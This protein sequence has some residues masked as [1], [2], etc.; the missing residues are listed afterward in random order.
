M[1]RLFLSNLSLRY[2]AQISCALFFSGEDPLL[3]EESLDA[4]Q[5]T[6]KRYLMKK[7][8]WKLIPLQTGMIC[9]SGCNPWAYFS[10]SRLSY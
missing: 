1:N 2:R 4:I 5:Q 6:S 9:S 8:S 10:I 3:I 7:S